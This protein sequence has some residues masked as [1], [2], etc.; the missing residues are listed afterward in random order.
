MYIKTHFLDHL[1]LLWSCSTRKLMFNE[2][3]WNYNIR[4][5]LLLGY[6]SFPVVQ[7]IVIL[8]LCGFD[9]GLILHSN[10][11][12]P[13]NLDH[14]QTR[15]HL[16]G[17]D[18]VCYSLQTLTE[19]VKFTKD[20]VLTELKLTLIWILSELFLGSL[21]LP[22]VFLIKLNAFIQSLQ[23]NWSVKK[24]DKFQLPAC[25][26]L[27]FLLSYST[28]SLLHNINKDQTYRL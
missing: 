19:S 1:I 20:V 5:K 16:H 10:S 6:L 25:H 22:L 9:N 27:Q 8:F 13:L 17:V 23:Q 12:N 18:H 26:N 2:C 21:E 28:I 11:V 7:D 24:R 14:V 4:F 3:C 15:K